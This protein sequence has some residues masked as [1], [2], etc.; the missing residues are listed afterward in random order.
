MSTVSQRGF[1][2]KVSVTF[3]GETRD[4][5]VFDTWSGGNVTADNT[6]HRRG[7]M[8]P[9][10]AI[11]GPKTLEDVTV[12]RDYDPPRDHGDAHWLSGAV[13]KARVV[14]SKSVLDED[15]NAF[16]RPLVVKGILIGYNHPEHDSD[17]GDTA[18]FEIVISPDGE[19]G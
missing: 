7:G 15:D 8:G 6:K 18:M 12:S 16:G 13:G 3:K 11:P 2:V 10:I 5:G 9:Q 17:S 1:E 14:A 19:V 4:L